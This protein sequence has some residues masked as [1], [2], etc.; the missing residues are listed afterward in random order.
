MQIFS[1]HAE[2]GWTVNEPLC[3]FYCVEWKENES[4]SNNIYDVLYGEALHSV[5]ICVC[6][7]ASS[8]VWPMQV[9]FLQTHVYLLHLISSI[10]KIQVNKQAITHY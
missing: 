2:A 10:N 8:C 6:E 3:G 9:N 7:H 5:Y 1:E 4:G